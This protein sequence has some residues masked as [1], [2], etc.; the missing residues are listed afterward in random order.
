MNSFAV[1]YKIDSSK[2]DAT[3]KVIEHFSKKKKTIGLAWV[4]LKVYNHDTMYD[5]NTK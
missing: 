1:K 2:F 3:A 5:R 4:F